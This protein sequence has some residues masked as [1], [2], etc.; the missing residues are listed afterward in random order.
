MDDFLRTFDWDKIPEIP[1]D[2]YLWFQIDQL[3]AERQ[4]IL[5]EANHEDPAIRFNP[6]LYGRYLANTEKLDKLLSLAKDYYQINQSYQ[7]AIPKQAY[8]ASAKFFE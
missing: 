1:Y 7:T 3:E 5:I 4:Q 8:Q 2:D 6:H